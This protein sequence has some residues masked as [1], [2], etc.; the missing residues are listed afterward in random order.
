MEL[1]TSSFGTTA[2]GEAVTKWTL[3]N[4][5]G[6]AVEVIDYGATTTAVRVPAAGGLPAQNVTIC[7]DDMESL[8]DAAKNP[9]MGATAG[10]VCNTLANA[11]VDDLGG[12]SYP[13]AANWNGSHHLHGGVKAFDKVM[14]RFVR[15]VLTSEYA[16]VV[17][18]YSSP[19]GEEGYPGALEVA[20]TFSLSQGSEFGVQYTA[21]VSGAATPVNLTNH[22]Y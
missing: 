5:A 3:S 14:W 11:R 10:R 15:S 6:M 12:R 16:A 22:C 2:A 19:D 9:Y 1:S 17:L 7:H 8:Q 20:A 18:A 21:T 13:L 4:G